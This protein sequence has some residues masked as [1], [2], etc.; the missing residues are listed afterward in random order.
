[1][2]AKSIRVPR[3]AAAPGGW[4]PRTADGLAVA[5]L[6][7]AA[8][9]ALLAVFARTPSFDWRTLGNRQPLFLDQFY[10]SE[11]DANAAGFPTKYWSQARSRI[12]IPGLGRGLWQTTLVLNGQRPSGPAATA[13]LASAGQATTLQLAPTVRQYHLLTPAAAGDWAVE[14]STAPFSPQQFTPASPD[15]RQLG[16]ILNHVAIAPVVTTS[17]PPTSAWWWLLGTLLLGYV[18]VRGSGLRPAWSLVLP[19]ALVGLIMVIV[20]HDRLATGLYLPR[21]F[22]GLAV[23]A[24]AVGAFR[25][26]WGRALR[27]GALAAPAWLL[28]VLLLIFVVGFVVKVAGVLYPYTITID[29]PW[30]MGHT[31]EILGGRLAELYQPGAFSESVMPVKEWGN[32]R[33][34]IPYSPFYHIF[35]AGFAIFP[36]RLEISANVFS[37]LLDTSRGFLLALL[38]LKVGLSARAAALAAALYA[39]TPFTFLLHSWGNTPTTMGMWWTLLATT[40]IVLGYERLDRPKVFALLTAVLLA[41]LL[42]YTVMAVFMGLFVVVLLVLLAIWGRRLPR[43]SALALG[44]AL[45]L[46]SVLSLLIYYGQYI[47]PIVERTLPYISRT[48]VGGQ[49]NTGQNVIE[50]LGVYVGNSLAHIGYSG[51]PNPSWSLAASLVPLPLLGP[52]YAAGPA[53][54]YGVVVPLVL[55]WPGLWLL[56]RNRLALLVWVAWSIVAWF[57]FFV[58]T[59]VSMV[60]KHLFYIV[61][62]LVITTGGVLDRAWQRWRWSGAVIALLYAGT[63]LS[64]L[65]LWLLRLQRVSL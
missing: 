22:G 31:R 63:L 59:R 58:G 5:L 60:D 65:A 30:H 26:L 27:F 20:N 19:L 40:L 52:T 12:A 55:G 28:P 7:V 47:G 36:W 49:Q 64:G 53:L 18:A 9:V 11:P 15:D 34:V 13:T 39:I 37:V 17:V 51:N 61:P 14:I 29:I 48:V 1:M 21:I 24:L 57:F 42:F 35:A 16:I 54:W 46:A 56:R 38:A 10:A 8:L 41:T 25:W 4:P 6:V 43:R 32:E 50:P 44:A 45:T 33:P 2:S 3:A 23:A 62:A